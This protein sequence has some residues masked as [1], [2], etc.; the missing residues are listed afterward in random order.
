MTDDAREQRER[1][2]AA[3]RARFQRGSRTGITD[4]QCEGY[5]VACEVL[6]AEHAAEIQR[7]RGEAMRIEDRIR[8]IADEANGPHPVLSAEDALTQIERAMFNA[9]QQIDRAAPDARSQLAGEAR[10][11][12]IAKLAGYDMTVAMVEHYAAY[13]DRLA[14]V[15]VAVLNVLG[16]TPNTET[17][18]G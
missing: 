10:E 1:G 9:R 5:V 3:A 7:V 12:V 11:A 15:I 8:T 18:D 4:A 16:A 6:R 14:K 13:G 17:S 2:L